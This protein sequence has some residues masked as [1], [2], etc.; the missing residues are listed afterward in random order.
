MKV[1]FVT[2]SL[3]T[4]GA[5]R[6]MLRLATSLRDHGVSVH[7]VC[8]AS[9]GNLES[10]FT[11]RG[12]EPV[13]L[14]LDEG[15]ALMA[16]ASHLAELVLDHGIQTMQGFMHLGDAM[17]GLASIRSGTRNVYWSIRTSTLPSE[18]ALSRRLL[19]F[20]LAPASHVIPKRI[21]SCSPAA[22]RHHVRKGYAQRKIVHI[23][24]SVEDW[25]LTSQSNS[26]LLT[27]HAGPIRIGMAARYEPGK[28]HIDLARAV[29][30]LRRRGWDV[31]SSFVGRGTGPGEALERDLLEAGLGDQA[32]H[33]GGL[34]DVTGV[35]DW[36]LYQVDVYAMASSKW[37]AFPNSLAEA[38][39][40]GLPTIA[41]NVGAAWSLAPKISRVSESSPTSL[42][43]GLHRLLKMDPVDRN[44]I[45]ADHQDFLR[46]RLNRL[47]SHANIRR[48]GG[49]RGGSAL[50][51]WRKLA[52]LFGHGLREVR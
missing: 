2:P 7:V 43:A 20:A 52:G 6:F 30:E 24:N 5:E 47:A 19:P 9:H 12:I 50:R 48:Y 34:Q 40:C 51:L 23:P 14:G 46:V 4:G 39:T 38:A 18:L 3:N 10:E 1:A 8:L 22:S 31:E 45:F 29:V 42:A 16:G 35:A 25:A 21:I 28:G 37:E 36:M 27:G 32:T 41:T 26:R 15:V 17:A 13:M 11:R 33:F 49:D 44:R